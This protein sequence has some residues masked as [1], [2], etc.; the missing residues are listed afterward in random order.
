MKSY[1]C[2]SCEKLLPCISFSVSALKR[3]DFKCRECK[4]RP[5]CLVS[6]CT[7]GLGTRKPYYTKG[8]KIPNLPFVISAAD[9][10]DSRCMYPPCANGCGTQ[11]PLQ[12]MMYQVENMPRWTCAACI[13]TKK[14]PRCAS[15]CGARRPQQ[16]TAYCVQQLPLWTCAACFENAC[17]YLPC[18]SGCGKRRPG[19][20]FIYHIQ[21]MPV[22]TCTACR[23]KV[24]MCNLF[25]PQLSG[26]GLDKHGVTE[27]SQP[28]NEHF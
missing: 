3:S 26:S 13:M 19:E 14:Y 18:V 24:I 28:T 27:S 1:F 11:R 23:K 21:N 6:S 10:T 15:G 2:I 5:K 25:L 9:A 8:H 17:K 4:S 12:A 20:A 7:S 16:R 22:W